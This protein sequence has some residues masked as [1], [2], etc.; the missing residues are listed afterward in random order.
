MSGEFGVRWKFK[1][2]HTPKRRQS[3]NGNGAGGLFRRKR[4]GTIMGKERGVGE[5]GEEDGDETG[6]EDSNDSPKSGEFALPDNGVP[7]VVVSGQHTQITLTTSR[8]IPG[9]VST[10]NLMSN[11]LLSPSWSTAPPSTTNGS[12]TPSYSSSPSKG[13]TSYVK[14]REHSVEWEQ[15]VSVVVRM[16]VE[17]DTLDLLPNELKLVIMQRVIPGDPDA[18]HNPRLGAV[19]LNLAE[20]VGAGSVTRRYLLRDSKT[21]ATLKV[22][23]ISLYL[24][25]MLITLPAVDN[26]YHP[27]RW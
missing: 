25:E 8:N 23:I 21:N 15:P 12:P 10:P 4:R 24:F 18:P 5:D 13:M 26:K 9:T 14:L 17:R 22:T 19:S 20:Y 11:S 16:D 27:R 7:S 2:V 6:D 3:G 1:D